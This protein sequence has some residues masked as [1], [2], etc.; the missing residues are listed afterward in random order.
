MTAQ[1][2]SAWIF[3]LIAVVGYATYL[4][5]VF[6][7]A[8]GGP[9]ADA[10]YEAPL[11]GTVVGAIVANIVVS[12]VVSI[13][14][15]TFG[16]RA[17]SRVDVRDVEISQLGERVGNAPLVL[18]SLV[19][20]VLALVDVDSFWVANALYLGFVLSAVLGTAARLTAY[21]GGFRRSGTLS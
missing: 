4:V 13:V 2:R 21:S 18:G 9:L 20:L 19:A 7:A 5:L 12:I 14:A 10:A 16:S 8:A 11:V 1:Q 17:S 3:G 6:A 15:G